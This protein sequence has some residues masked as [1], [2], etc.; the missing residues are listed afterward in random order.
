MVDCLLLACCCYSLGGCEGKDLQKPIGG[1]PSNGVNGDH[2]PL[3]PRSE[4]CM[5]QNHM[6]ICEDLSTSKNIVFNV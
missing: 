6:K 4:H 1:G 3:S 5:G 2:L